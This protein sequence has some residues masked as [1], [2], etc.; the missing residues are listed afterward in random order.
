MTSFKMT[1]LLWGMILVVLF[2]RPTLA[3]G[4]GN[5]A[6]I[7]KVEGQNCEQLLAYDPARWGLLTMPFDV[8]GAMV[9]Y[10]TRKTNTLHLHSPGTALCG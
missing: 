6:G 5:I 10:V 8:Q 3:F 9:M 4:A 7:S 1:P 2:A